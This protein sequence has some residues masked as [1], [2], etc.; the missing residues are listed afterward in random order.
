MDVEA[1]EIPDVRILRPRKFGDHRGFFS[2]T[3]NKQALAEAGIDLDFV[4]D[5]HSLSGEVGTLR[6]LHFQTPPFGQDKLVRVVRGAI[7]DVA[8]DLR[9]GSPTYGKH[10][11]AEISAE[12]WNQILVPIGFAHGFITLTPDVE[13]IYKVTNYYA[14]AHDKG[15]LWSDPA[16]GIDWPLPPGGPI[17]SDKDKVQPTLAEID[18]PF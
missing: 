17:L 15:L 14:P 11:A 4:Q 7:L 16:L 2:E 10:V 13:V 5:N 1:L 8:V 18:A 6:G 9:K 12:A 3:Y